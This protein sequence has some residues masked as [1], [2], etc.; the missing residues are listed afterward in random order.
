MKGS[1]AV[2]VLFRCVVLA[3]LVYAMLLTWW[4]PFTG[5]SFMHSVFGVQHRLSFW[6]VLER[7]W[8]SYLNWNPRLGEFL[9]IFTATAGKWLF[10]LVN[11]F[12]VL[13]LALM[14][15]YLARGRRVRPGDWRDVLL[16]TVGGLLLLTSSSRPGITMFWLSGGTNYAWA[17]AVWLGFLC[18][19]RGLWAGSSRIQDRPFSWFWIGAAGFAAGMTNENQVPAS[20]GML[21]LFWLYAR[22]KGRSLPRWFFAGWAAHAIGGACLLLAPGNTARLHSETAGGAAVLQSWGERFGSIPEL[23]NAFY[24][25]MRLPKV[26]LAVAALALA[27]LAWRQGRRVWSGTTGRRVSASLLFILVAHAMAVSFFVRVVP[28]WH[29]MFSATVLMMTGVLGLYGVWMDRAPRPWVPACILAA[30]GGLALWVCAGYLDAFPRIH[31]QCE[32][33]RA[34]IRHELAQGKRNIVVPPYEPMPLAPYV[35]VMWRMCSGDPDEFINSS[36]ARYLGIESIRVDVCGDRVPQSWR[37]FK[38]SGERD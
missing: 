1:F 15:F 29:A 37:Y 16:F 14:M 32:E 27:L 25:F 19:Y 8:W 31:R 4:T 3:F 6:P 30:A 23:L 10:C 5:D 38:G 24:E 18:L 33:R 28:A 26:L 13:S 34:F 12:V 36:V 2:R 22:W 9:A 7:C 17:A 21:F 20:L 11:P 35:S